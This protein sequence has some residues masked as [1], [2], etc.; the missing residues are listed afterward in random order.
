VK[1]RLQKKRISRTVHFETV[2]PD[3]LKEFNLEKSFTIE[4]IKSKWSDITG[5]II[6]T[7]TMPDRIFKGTLFVAV[8][9][10]VFANEVVMMKDLLIKK[11]RDEFSYTGIINVKAEV[12]KIRWR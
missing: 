10:P 1:F 3:I 4:T 12:K 11:I 8:D 2:L 6:S 5:D 9:H 7:H